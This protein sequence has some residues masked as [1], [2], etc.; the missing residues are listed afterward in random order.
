M[1]CIIG[2]EHQ[3]KVYIGC[4]S[5]SLNGWAKDITAVKKVFRKGDMLIG[6]AGNPRQMQIL[7][8]FVMDMPHPASM[9]DEEYLVRT[10]VEQARVAFRQCGFTETD[11]GRE[12]GAS[13]LI[14]YRGKL[15]SVENG[16]QLCR[17]ARGYTAMG[18]GDDFALGALQALMSEDEYMVQ[19]LPPEILLRRSL[20]VAGELSSGVCG[21]Y[22]V[23]VL[24][25]TIPLSESEQKAKGDLVFESLMKAPLEPSPGTNATASPLPKGISYT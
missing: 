10:I 7:Q 20:E 14:G 23:E 21:P 4:D 24:D 18:V 5:I 25:T 3:G 6:I 9:T 13:F 15:Y 11:N 16:F 8:Y 12:T 22:Y 2:L 17:S 19:S 1:T